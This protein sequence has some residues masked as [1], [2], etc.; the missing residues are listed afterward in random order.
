MDAPIVIYYDNINN[1]LLANNQVYHA[2][3]KYIEVHYY[4]V[5]EKL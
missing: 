3:T 2:R 1:M 5:K 4:L